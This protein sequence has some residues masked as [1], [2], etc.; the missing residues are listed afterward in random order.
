M[1][2]RFEAAQHCCFLVKIFLV[3][4]W[5][6]NPV[7]CREW[8]RS[9]LTALNED[10]IARFPDALPRVHSFLVV[11]SREQRFCQTTQPGPIVFQDRV[12]LP[13]LLENDG[14]LGLRVK[15]HLSKRRVVLLVERTTDLLLVI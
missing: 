9:S 2:K 10:V 13:I 14:G 3:A 12:G 7:S 5:P 8:W 15:D 1:V 11:G 6:L 4:I